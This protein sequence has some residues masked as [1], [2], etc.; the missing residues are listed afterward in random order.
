MKSLITATSY[1]EVNDILGTGCD[2]LDI[3]NPNEGSLGA[4]APQKTSRIMDL[5]TEEVVTSIAIGDAP[6][7][8]GTVSLAAKGAAHLEPDYIKVGLK[9]PNNIEEAVYMMSQVVETIREVEEDIKV[10]TAGYGDYIRAGTINPMK[11]P[12]VAEKTGSSVVLLDTAIKDGKSLLDHLSVDKIRYFVEKCHERGLLSAV[13]GSLG[14]DD[15][16]TISRTNA[17][18]FGVRGA[19]CSDGRGSNIVRAKVE[20]LTEEISKYD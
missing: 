20:E 8:P 9:G 3:K 2:I 16:E 10:V 17:D 12:K 11:L 14:I 1:E 7:L 15:V 13:A 6:N 19:V 5:T 18:I 4:N